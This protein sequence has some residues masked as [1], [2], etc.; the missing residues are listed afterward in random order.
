MK[1]A[2]E[3]V[4]FLLRKRKSGPHASLKDGTHSEFC[5]WAAQK[6]KRKTVISI[7]HVQ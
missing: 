6:L 2:F 5:R 1:V 4:A 7:T 3:C